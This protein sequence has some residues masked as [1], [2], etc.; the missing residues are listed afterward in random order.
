MCAFRVSSHQLYQ[1]TGDAI[2]ASPLLPKEFGAGRIP[3]ETRVTA[4]PRGTMQAVSQ[5]I[6]SNKRKKILMAAEMGQLNAVL[7]APS[8]QQRPFH[9]IQVRQES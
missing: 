6:T 8:F 2:I 7:A 4:Q 5:S 3:V 1:E 9:A